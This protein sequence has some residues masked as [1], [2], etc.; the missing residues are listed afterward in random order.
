MLTVRDIDN[1]EYTVKSIWLLSGWR[2]VFMD[3]YRA[4]HEIA[5]ECFS[6][7]EWEKLENYD[8][9]DLD[10]EEVPPGF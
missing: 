10:Q 5:R 1:N 8:G 4:W 3:A 2:V 9:T 7:E 6:K